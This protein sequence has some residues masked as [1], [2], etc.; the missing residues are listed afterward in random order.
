MTCRILHGDHT[1]ESFNVQ[2]GVRQWWHLSPFIFLLA[3]EWV[4]RDKQ[5]KNKMAFSGL[6]SI[7]WTIWTLHKTL[8]YCHTTMNRCWRKQ[9]PFNQQ[10]R[11]LA[12]D[13]YIGDIGDECQ[14]WQN[15]SN[16]NWWQWVRRCHFSHL[17]GQHSG[18]NWQYGSRHPNQGRKKVGQRTFLFGTFW[19]HVHNQDQ[20]KLEYLTAMWKQSSFEL[21]RT[22]VSSDK[23]E[24]S[25]INVCLRGILRWPNC[26]NNK[27][28]CQQT[29]QLLPPLQIRKRKLTW[30]VHN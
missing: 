3:I 2:L 12:Q 6:Y 13:H 30:I 7:S 11:R 21:R 17:R 5:T 9:P 18:H 4:M 19:T 20:Q 28:L 23:R 26:I 29:N 1:S 25:F 24:Q 22:N 16:Q 27:D 8:L 10:L 14:H 15:R